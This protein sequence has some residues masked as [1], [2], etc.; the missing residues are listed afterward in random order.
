MFEKCYRYW[1]HQEGPYT[2][3]KR[4]KYLGLRGWKGHIQKK[5]YDNVEYAGEVY[6]CI[7]P[8]GKRVRGVFRIPY[9]DINPTEKNYEENDVVLDEITN[10]HT[11]GIKAYLTGNFKYRD[12]KSLILKQEQ[13]T[14]KISKLKE[15]F[16]RLNNINDQDLKLAVQLYL[17]R[18][19][20]PDHYTSRDWKNC[21]LKNEVL[22]LYN[23]QEK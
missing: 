7:T 20:T 14:A 1:A 12:N 11:D 21:K 2:F 23:E 4:I 22:T 19:E 6:I 5:S 15:I 16:S 3:V 10:F 8:E 18:L 9:E 13:L 17:R